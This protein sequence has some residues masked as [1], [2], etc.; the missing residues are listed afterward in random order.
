VHIVPTS[1]GRDGLASTWLVDPYSS[2]ILFADWKELE[3]Q[4]WMWPIRETY[5]PLVV[6]RPESWL[7]ERAG[8]ARTARF[9]RARFRAAGRHPPRAPTAPTLAVADPIDVEGLSP[10]LAL[11][12]QF[13]GTAGSSPV[14]SASCGSSARARARSELAV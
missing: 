3:G 8:G 7:P 11:P 2:G 14:G 9:P 4:A 5:D 1:R 10:N 13:V 12:G 6:R